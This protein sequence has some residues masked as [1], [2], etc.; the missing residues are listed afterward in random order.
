MRDSQGL[1]TLIDNQTFLSALFK[2][3]VNR[4]H[5]TVFHEDPN[6]LEGDSR[7]AWAGGHWGNLM[8]YFTNGGNQY[9]TISTF[10]P[11]ETGRARRRK[12]LFDACYLVV[13][14]DVGT[15]PSAKVDPNDPRLPYPS[16]KLET[17]PGNEQWGYI[18]SLPETDRNRVDNLLDGMVAAKLCP[19]GSDPGMKGVTRYV[20][21]PEGTNNKQKYIDVL[22][23]PFACR[24]TYWSPTNT[25]T[26]EQLAARFGVDLDAPRESKE[27][28]TITDEQHPGL[29]AYADQ[30]DIKSV[31]EP[32]KYDVV[33]PNVEHHTDFD[34]SGTA[35]WTYPDGR[36]GFKCHHGHCEELGGGWLMSLL[37]A[38]DPTLRSRRAEYNMNFNVIEHP[39][40]TEVEQ[41]ST[42][43]IQ[44][45][46]TNI[47]VTEAGRSLDLLIG[48]LTPAATPNDI[49]VVL[50]YMIEM[51]PIEREHYI[52]LIHAHTSKSKNLLREQLKDL[53]R[54]ARRAGT[55]N[56]TTPEFIHETEAGGARTTLENFNAILEHQ[57]IQ[58]RYNTMIRAVEIDIPG[59]EFFTDTARNAQ[60]TRL[61]S[62]LEQYGMNSTKVKKY[63]AYMAQ[64]NPYHPFEEYLD[65]AGDWDGVDRI[66]MLADTLKVSPGQEKLRDTLLRRWLVSVPAAVMRKTEEDPMCVGEPEP[67]PRGILTLQGSQY[68][69]KTRWFRRITPDGFF[70]EGLQLTGDKDGIKQATNK[71]IVEIG[72]AD[73]SVG[74]RH[75]G[76]L[77]AFIG[78]DFDEVRLP[79]E[80]EETRWPRRTVFGGTVNPANFLKDETGNSRWWVLQ[81]TSIDFNLLDIID[82]QQLWLQAAHLYECGEPYL[83]TKAEMEALNESNV[84]SQ[85]VSHFEQWLLDTYHFDTMAGA[86]NKANWKTTSQLVSK[87]KKEIGLSTPKPAVL[88]E[89]LKRLTNSSNV[90]AWVGGHSARAWRMPDMVDTF[91]HDE[92]QGMFDNVTPEQCDTSEVLH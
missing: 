71:M 40:Q 54:T 9:F 69:G 87:F 60:L 37:D 72:E 65:R 64:F 59:V 32:G 27:G 31:I 6:S 92:G 43:P 51:Q 75:V 35:I 46:P 38:N 52:D 45:A 86:D 63:S 50:N 91:N 25:L 2:G 14:D 11:D 83:L 84:N 19:D 22:G 61:V 68:M 58:V 90:V 77:K 74:G 78:R 17:S 89:I 4:A 18:L 66:R 1:A 44:L 55:L 24:I 15:G 23:A 16:Y 28:L 36:L 76:Q 30:F 29:L 8:G 39:P 85:E 57:G 70:K 49:V 21:L 47:P 12:A 34:D 82:I 10:K 67:A 3:A 20:R 13:V 62:L 88:S 48:D 53:K 33:C 81:L 5:V 42:A 41:A 80:E 73:A 7:K 56:T 26:I 79:W